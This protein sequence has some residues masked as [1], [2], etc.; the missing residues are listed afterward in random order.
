MSIDTSSREFTINNCWELADGGLLF[1]RYGFLSTLSGSLG[2]SLFW[3]S[4]LWRIICAGFF[5][6]ADANGGADDEDWQRPTAEHVFAERSRLVQA[7]YDPEAENF[8]ANKLLA[9]RTQV[10]KDLVAFS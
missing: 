7:F 5:G 1:L 3:P 6:D 9:R 4:R 10:T 8:D 2:Q